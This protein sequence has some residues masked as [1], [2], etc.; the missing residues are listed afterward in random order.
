M[1]SL[2][3]GR[4]YSVEST[5]ETI[6]K[7]IKE[8]FGNVSNLYA[9]LEDQIKGKKDI[10]ATDLGNLKFS[11]VIYKAGNTEIKKDFAIDMK[12]VEMDKFDRL[13]R[14]V[15]KIATKGN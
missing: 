14:I 3:D 4:V 8:F 15:K 9:V 7:A 1:V 10:M 12:E 6:D 2:L 11:I 5:D 13:E